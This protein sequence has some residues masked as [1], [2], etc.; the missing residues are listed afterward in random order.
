MAPGVC[1]TRAVTPALPRAPTPT[2]HTTDFPFDLPA[3]KP[4]FCGPTGLLP[5]QEDFESYSSFLDALIRYDHVRRLFESVE[6]LTLEQTADHGIIPG[7]AVIR[8]FIG[9]STT[10]IPHNE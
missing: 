5:R 3:L 10:K 4:Y 9:G 7:D 8:E 2:G 6:G 1:S